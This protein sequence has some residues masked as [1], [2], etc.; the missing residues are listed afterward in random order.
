MPS[1]DD[2]QPRAVGDAYRSSGRAAG[3]AP[4][5][6]IEDG[7][8][9][10]RTGARLP[11]LC[12]KCGAS[13]EMRW[14]K[15]LFA[16]GA[17]PAPSFGKTLL[18]GALFGPFGGQLAR[19]ASQ[20]QTML[21]LPLCSRCNVRVTNRALLAALGLVG[22]LGTLLY[23]VVTVADHVRA[24]ERWL[25]LLELLGAF[26]VMA[27]LGRFARGAQLVAKR[28]DLDHVVLDGVPPAV[29]DAIAARVLRKKKAPT[30]PAASDESSSG[31]EP[32]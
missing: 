18:L 8:L 1:P 6:W 11:A 3:P 23:E 31:R 14:R 30:S 32:G 12:L 4:R 10:V 24:H 19:G 5:A 17:R 7:G 29:R 2:D 15:Q 20:Q 13:G 21:E 26:V 16:V 27:A 9:A 28:A 25:V 22:F